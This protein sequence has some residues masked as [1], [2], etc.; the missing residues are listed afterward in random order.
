M[1]GSGA[2]LV[3]GLF[4]G[5]PDV[6]TLVILITFAVSLIVDAGI[7]LMG[8]FGMPHAS[9][10]AAKAAHEISKG[11]YKDYFWVGSL[12]IGHI[13]PLLFLTFGNPFTNA[14]AGVCAIIGLYAFEYAFVM[15]PQDVP[16]S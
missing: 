8:E 15:A 10:V 9:E 7:T 4:V 2:L 3:A 11:R 1:A 13:V 5:L 14:I 6:M 16:N 12:L